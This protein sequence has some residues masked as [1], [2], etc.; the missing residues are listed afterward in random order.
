MGTLNAE[1]QETVDRWAAASIVKK[2]IEEMVEVDKNDLIEAILPLFLEGWAT[3][4]QQPGNPRMGTTD[5]NCSLVVKTGKSISLDLHGQDTPEEALK[6]IGLHHARAKKFARYAKKRKQK[7]LLGS[8]ESML[9]DPKTKDAAKALL[10]AIEADASWCALLSVHNDYTVAKPDKFAQDLPKDAA[11]ADEMAKVCRVFRPQVYPA[12]GVHGDA[13]RAVVKR[14]K[15]EAAN[16]REHVLPCGKHRIAAVGK[17]V[18]IY[19]KIDGK[20]KHR[21]SIKY[22]SPH[23]AQESAQALAGDAAALKSAL[24]A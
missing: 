10:A 21:R 6:A 8:F 24:L 1:Q 19:E 22:D 20:W 14:Q 4:K 2:L 23:Q 5:A 11:D 13:V 3:E 12:Q 17:Q 7:E 9:A 16:K 18:R 15:F